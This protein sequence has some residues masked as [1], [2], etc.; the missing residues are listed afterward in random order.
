[1]EARRAVSQ[2]R[3]FTINPTQWKYVVGALCQNLS[4]PDSSSFARCLAKSCL[5]TDLPQ[6][7]LDSHALMLSARNS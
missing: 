2:S 3:S 6:F 5:M 7:A 1:M 4:S